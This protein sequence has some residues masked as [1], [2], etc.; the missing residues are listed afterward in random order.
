MDSRRERRRNWRGRGGEMAYLVRTLA[1]RPEF[2]SPSLWKMS[3]VFGCIC[4][5]LTLVGWEWGK[6]EPELVGH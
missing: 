1:L 4:A 2:D 3:S 6:V 5:P